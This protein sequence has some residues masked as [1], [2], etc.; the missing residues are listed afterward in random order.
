MFDSEP[1][2]SQ[3]NDDRDAQLVTRRVFLVT[4]IAAM[5]GVALLTLRHPHRALANDVPAHPAGPVVVVLFSDDGKRLQ[6]V[7]MAKVVKSAS[8]WQSQLSPNVYDIAR[9]AD[10]E[11]PYSGSLWNQHKR[12]LYRCICCDTALFSSDTKFESGTGWPSFWAPVAKEN[13]AEQ[14]DPTLGMDRTAVS[15]RL[16]DAHLGHVFTD[17]P[18]PTGLRYCM[19]SASLR[20]IPHS[21]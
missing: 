19:N 7:K 17:G 14:N 15:C 3:S 8:E 9:L 11:V 6:K 1:A 16:C 5:G 2:D 10:T 20:F 12:G 13:V 21:A 4:G 18:Q